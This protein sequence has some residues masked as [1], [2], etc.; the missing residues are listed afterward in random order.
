MVVIVVAYRNC[1]QKT[2]GAVAAGPRQRGR[3]GRDKQKIARNPAGGNLG[4]SRVWSP[5]R[6]SVAG[7]RLGFVPIV[8]KHRVAAAAAPPPLSS[9]GGPLLAVRCLAGWL[10]RW[11]ARQ[12]WRRRS[13]SA[14]FW[15]VTVER[16][17]CARLGRAFV[18]Q[19]DRDAL[20]LRL[21][22]VATPPWHEP[23]GSGRSTR[24]R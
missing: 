11:L 6:A 2:G 3:R 24:R 17:L 4:R 1:P 5:F 21:A 23:A 22:G 7:P 9:L 14:T 20:M 10:A 15:S 19:E 8:P 18:G 13:A 16:V 12:Q